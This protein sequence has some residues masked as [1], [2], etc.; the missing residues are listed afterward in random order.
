MSR[1]TGPSDE[2]RNANS[3]LVRFTLF[4]VREKGCPPRAVGRGMRMFT[5]R[6]VA[7]DRADGYVAVPSVGG[8][9]TTA[10]RPCRLHEKKISLPFFLVHKVA[11]Q[12]STFLHTWTTGVHTRVCTHIYK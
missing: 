11:L 2:F 3:G 10:A 4:S 6:V 5:A 7:L 1:G 12:L 9:P 8:P